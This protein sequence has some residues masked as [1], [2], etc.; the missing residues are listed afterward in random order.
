[1]PLLFLCL[2][3]YKIG[4]NCTTFCI[5]NAHYDLVAFLT[6]AYLTILTL[7]A[8]TSICPR[9][10]DCKLTQLKTP[11][12]LRRQQNIIK[13]TE[14]GGVCFAYKYVLL[15]LVFYYYYCLLSAAMS[16]WWSVVH[17]IIT[18]RLNKCVL[19]PHHAN[20]QKK[21]TLFVFICWTVVQ[22]FGLL[23]ALIVWQLFEEKTSHSLS[24]AERNVIT[25]Q[26]NV[27][28]DKIT[29]VA[30]MY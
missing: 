10:F 12:S 25:C 21:F 6:D 23:L 8:N 17:I 3:M 2:E 11:P 28:E 24:A 13:P 30:T 26:I 1:M 14:V 18:D 19:P 9:W 27:N 20:P 5:L 4:Y 29:I 22:L 16:V 15:L 7:N